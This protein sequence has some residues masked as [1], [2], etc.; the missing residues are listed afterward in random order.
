MKHPTGV[1]DA[2]AMTNITNPT[3]SREFVIPLENRPGTIAEV[4]TSLGKANVN[5]IGFLVEAQGEFGI[6]RVITSDPAKTEGW[7]KQTN[8]P[9]RAN[10]VVIAP[11]K[12]QPGE[13]GRVASKLAASGVNI[14]ASYPTEN[15][16]IAFAVNDVNGAKK[17]L[18]I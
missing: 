18:G 5:I 13:L 11:V 2:V 7:L 3:T 15:G 9:Y 6:A 16:G 17:V 12:P 1:W 8:R 10:D 4:A 14:N